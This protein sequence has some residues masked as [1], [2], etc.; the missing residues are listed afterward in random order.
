AGCADSD[1]PA[2]TAAQA[3]T[4]ES[5]EPAQPTEDATPDEPAKPDPMAVAEAIR[6]AVPEVTEVIELTPENDPNELLG[7]PGQY[8]AAVLLVD[9]RTDCDVSGLGIDCG[10]KIE[11]WASEA[12]AQARLDD[13]QQKLKDFGL[14]AEW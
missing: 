14:G 9:G 2:G 11:R 6:G 4:S 1:E 12:D 5:P 13:I 10:A 7:R 3:P 8:D